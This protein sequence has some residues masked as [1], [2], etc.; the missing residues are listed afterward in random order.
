MCK[1]LFSTAAALFASLLFL[2]Q[3]ASQASAATLFTTNVSDGPNW[4][5]SALS[6]GVT[7]VQSQEIVLT[8]VSDISSFRW[9]GRYCS[10]DGLA[11]CLKTGYESFLDDFYVQIGGVA[12][13]NQPVA[14]SSDLG[15]SSSSA[16]I[17]YTL[18]LTG[19]VLGPGTYTVSIW[20][21][22]ASDPLFAWYWDFGGVTGTDLSITVIGD[23]VNPVPLPVSGLLLFAGLGALGFVRSRKAG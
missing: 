20:N 11:G 22:L 7:S 6:D 3:S 19:L 4:L 18:L 10:L 9:T 14:R 8:D 17:E 15:W 1:R 23:V 5:G 2:S 16:T 13:L 12:T 21:E